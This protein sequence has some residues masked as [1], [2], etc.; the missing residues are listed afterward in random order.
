MRFTVCKR[1]LLGTLL[2][3]AW[4]M[5]AYGAEPD[6]EAYRRGIEEYEASLYGT[7]FDSFAEADRQMPENGYIYYRMGS[8]M[9]MLGESQKA[10]DYALKSLVCFGPDDSVGLSDACQFIAFLAN[11]S[12]DDIE[13]LSAED[14]AKYYD[15]AVETAPAYWKAYLER[16][17]Y[18]NIY[19]NE[20]ARSDADYKKAIELH[21]KEVESYSRLIWS[22]QERGM[23][24]EAE[25][26]CRKCIAAELDYPHHYDILC[27]LLLKKGKVYE[28]RDILWQAFMKCDDYYFQGMSAVMRFPEEYQQWF[29]NQIRAQAKAHPDRPYWQKYLE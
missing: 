3:G 16:G 22:Y 23:D 25:E 14:A 8:A 2:A 11:N 13:G 20:Y 15:K 4:M 27:E 21:P 1:A 19:R 9:Y 7:S 12:S 29:I 28:A 6:C 24:D 5:S 10:Y 18:Y 26:Y 17:N